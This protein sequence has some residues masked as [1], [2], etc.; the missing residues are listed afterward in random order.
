MKILILDDH[1]AIQYFVKNQIEEIIQNAEII[2]CYSIESAKIAM[3]EF[4]SNDFAFCDLEINKGCTTEIPELCNQ[5]KIPYMIYSSH[6]NKILINELSTMHV[7]CYVSKTSGIN[8]LRDG[9]ISLFN[10]RQYFCPLVHSTIE[11]NDAFKETQKLILTRGQQIVLEVL[12]KG[13]NRME[14]A[15]KLNL[16]ITTLNNHISRA[17]ELNDCENFEEL[18]RRYRFWDLIN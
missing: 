3:K 10:Y 9:L 15:K 5:M 6:V 7:T 4:N 12:S 14:A 16:K 2:Q 13:F 17:R 11:S 18:L 8:H 1:T